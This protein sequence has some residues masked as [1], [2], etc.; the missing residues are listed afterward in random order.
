MSEQLPIPQGD[1]VFADGVPVDDGTWSDGAFSST[2]QDCEDGI[3]F[4]IRAEGEVYL[5]GGRQTPVGP[6]GVESAD[7]A[8][9]FRSDLPR[10]ALIAGIEY[11]DYAFWK[12]IG[13]GD[14]FVCEGPGP[15]TL[16]VNDSAWGDNEGGFHVTVWKQSPA[17]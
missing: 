16:G 10:G 13:I 7:T 1:S 4:V 8:D 3:A 12:A 6:E 5:D 15:F 17:Q 2:G 9:L 14:T 11:N